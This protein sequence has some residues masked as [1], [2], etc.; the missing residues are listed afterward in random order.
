MERPE[1]R[2]LWLRA[3]EIHPNPMQPRHTRE[4]CRSV[5]PSLVYCIVAPFRRIGLRPLPAHLVAQVIQPLQLFLLEMDF[6]QCLVAALFQ[7]AHALPG[8]V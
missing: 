8:G 4:T 3:E 2:V 1:Q 6:V 5:F 7:H